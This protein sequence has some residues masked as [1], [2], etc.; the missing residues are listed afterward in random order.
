L[1]QYTFGSL[2]NFSGQFTADPAAQTLG[3]TFDV[4]TSFVNPGTTTLSGT[5]SPSA[6]PN[7]LSGTLADPNFFLIP[8]GSNIGINVDYYLT[9]PTHGFFLETDLGD[10]ILNGSTV[11]FGYFGKTTF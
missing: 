1:S 4:N 6:Q 9:D 3:G 10:P 11:T 8:N 5:F 2:T 7:V